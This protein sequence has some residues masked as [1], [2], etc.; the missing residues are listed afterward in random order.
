MGSVNFKFFVLFV[1]YVH[2][3]NFSYFLYQVKY[4]KNVGEYPQ[5]VTF[6]G[7]FNLS[8]SIEF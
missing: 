3:G 1:S 6:V 8:L 2:F 4:D 5:H 7:A